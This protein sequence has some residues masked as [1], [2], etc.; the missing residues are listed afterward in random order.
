MDSIPVAAEQLHPLGPA[1]AAI[2]LGSRGV[3]ASTDERIAHS[4]V[5]DPSDF[6]EG[7][8]TG[9]CDARAARL[10][11]GIRRDY[12]FDETFRLGVATGTMS[13]PRGYDPF[14][15]KELRVK[16]VRYERL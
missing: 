2:T 9:A 3:I 11:A 6:H 12:P 1:T 16:A 13:L 15:P 8:P 7:N 4:F 10:L 14:R 5:S